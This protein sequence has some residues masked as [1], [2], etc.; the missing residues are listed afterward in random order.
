MLSGQ[1]PG[2]FRLFGLFN[3]SSCGFAMLS[4]QCCQVYFLVSGRGREAKRRQK[5]SSLFELII[6][7]HASQVTECLRSNG[8]GTAN[9]IGLALDTK[10]RHLFLHI[11]CLVAVARSRI[12]LHKIS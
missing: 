7:L 2:T 12:R 9:E 3:L 6:D 11:I 4:D 10:L 5:A 8:L 1:S